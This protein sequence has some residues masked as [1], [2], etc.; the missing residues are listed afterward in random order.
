MKSCCMVCNKILRNIKLT[1][2]GPFEHSL[3][4]KVFSQGDNAEKNT[5]FSHLSAIVL[6]FF[7]RLH[8]NSTCYRNA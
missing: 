2:F 6:I 1:N 3:D 4:R 8:L 5:V 7:L